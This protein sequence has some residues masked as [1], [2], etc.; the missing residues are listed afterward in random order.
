[1]RSIIVSLEAIA[2]A[3]DQTSDLSK[4]E[5]KVM[6][7][8]GLVK[9]FVSQTNKPLAGVIPA[10]TTS[11]G[12]HE[13]PLLKELDTELSIWQSKLEVI[14]KEPVG[15]KGMAKHARFWA[16]KLRAIHV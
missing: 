15:K 12:R 6:A 3:V 10:T 9:N 4:V 13:L 11:A 2:Y 8:R 14:L 7:T 1:M 16:E 5:E